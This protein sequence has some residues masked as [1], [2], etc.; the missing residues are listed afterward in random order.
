MSQIGR[1]RSAK[2]G[3]ERSGGLRL[4]LLRRG[5]HG[6][7]SRGMAGQGRARLGRRGLDSQGPGRNGYAINPPTLN[8]V[9]GLFYIGNSSITLLEI[10][11]VFARSYPCFVTAVD[12]WART[13]RGPSIDCPPSTSHKHNNY[14]PLPILSL[15][16]FTLIYSLLLP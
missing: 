1:M 11:S 2:A 3:T 8:R 9:G 14:K 12:E 6:Q 4:G 15:L 5:R 7:A 16:S 13:R 10:V